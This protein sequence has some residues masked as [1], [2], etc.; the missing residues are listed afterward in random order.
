MVGLDFPE[1]PEFFHRPFVC[2]VN[3]CQSNDGVLIGIKGQ[4]DGGSSADLARDLLSYLASTLCNLE[5]TASS[6]PSLSCFWYLRA[7]SENSTFP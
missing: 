6:H 2:I 7:L 1:V 3:C 5:Q 4:Y